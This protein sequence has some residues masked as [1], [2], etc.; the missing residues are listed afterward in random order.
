MNRCLVGAFVAAVAIAA[1]VRQTSTTFPTPPGDWTAYGR[2]ALGDRHSPLN[3]IRRDNVSRLQV[4]WRYNTGEARRPETER[5]QVSL[6]ATPFVHRATMYRRTPFG[7][8]IAL[9]APTGAERWVRDLK[10][11]ASLRFGDF[12]SRGVS[13]WR[14]ADADP[15][16]ACAL[17]V[18]AATIDSRLTAL[19]AETGAPCAQFGAGGTVDLLT[20]LRNTP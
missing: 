10:V 14:D 18:I 15:A 19:D 5:A 17:R 1:C 4:A 16:I 8:I 6:D 11:D 9:D 13:L 20:G 12:T 7:R 3:E 2:T